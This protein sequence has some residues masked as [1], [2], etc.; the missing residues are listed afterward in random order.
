MQPSTN[1][2]VHSAYVRVAYSAVLNELVRAMTSPAADQVFEELTKMVD[3]V[4]EGRQ[5]WLW[6]HA[7]W[8]LDHGQARIAEEFLHRRQPRTET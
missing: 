4:R 1:G 6:E 8:G 5:P 3:D 7:L 2:R